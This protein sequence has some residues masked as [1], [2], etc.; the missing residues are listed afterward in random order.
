MFYRLTISF[1]LLLVKGIGAF[2]FGQLNKI[3]MMRK[4]RK[5]IIK[6]MMVMKKILEVIVFK[7][8]ELNLKL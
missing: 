8:I 4:K 2:L 7:R 3:L 5:I 1:W 6:I